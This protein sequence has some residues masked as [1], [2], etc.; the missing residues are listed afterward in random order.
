MS[1]K[2]PRTLLVKHALRAVRLVQVLMP[3][4]LV[5][6][7]TL[8]V[9]AF[10]L[11]AKISALNVQSTLSKWERNVRPAGKHILLQLI[12][13]LANLQDARTVNTT[14]RNLWLAWAAWPIAWPVQMHPLA[15]LA[16]LVMKLL[17]TILVTLL[18]M[19]MLALLDNFI[20]LILQHV[21]VALILV[22]TAM[23]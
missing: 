16:L 21:I 22:L 20:I 4:L 9:M 12:K 2:I 18:D 15:P 5:K 14:I 17:L 13:S 6:L 23:P 8:W 3:A 10:A 7:L 1:L 19:I 11:L